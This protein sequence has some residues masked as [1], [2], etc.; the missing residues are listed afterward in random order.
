MLCVFNQ[1]LSTKPSTE[2]LQK[3]VSDGILN[4][5]KNDIRYILASYNHDKSINENKCNNKSGSTQDEQQQSSTRSSLS[6]EYK[7]IDS[8]NAYVYLWNVQDHVIVVD[9]DGTLTKSD[10]RGVISTIVKKDYT[11]VHDGMCKFFSDLV[12]LTRVP[13]HNIND[14]N[15]DD[16]NVWEKPVTETRF[17]ILPNNNFGIT[18]HSSNKN[19]NQTNE[20]TKLE[21]EQKYLIGKIRVLYLS[22]RPLQLMDSTRKFLS[23][24]S[25]CHLN[26][27]QSKSKSREIIGLTQCMSCFNPSINQ[28]ENDDLSKS[29]T[30][31]FDIICGDKMY[32]RHPDTLA[33]AETKPPSSKMLPDDW[34]ESKSAFSQLPAGPILLNTESLS[35]VLVSELNKSVYKYK[36]N[37]LMR[38]VVLPFTAAGKESNQKCTNTVS[39]TSTTRIKDNI[40]FIAGFGNKA[41][42]AKAYEIAGMRK[43]DIFIIDKKSQIS[44]YLDCWENNNADARKEGTTI[45]RSERVLTFSGYSDQDL[46][47]T[48]INKIKEHMT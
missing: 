19:Q 16:C 32:E 10:V 33:K 45:K 26:E 34:D 13:K 23:Q 29:D 6:C 22:S 31:D 48:M 5:G 42:D 1:G 43:E 4:E 11:H 20:I 15:T 47:K 30:C 21:K 3:L 46:T 35:S 27:R 44:C 38:Q 17:P 24:V 8:V 28:I 14:S 2:V 12:N 37:T 39:N 7:P 18:N 25:Q 40:I 9:I 36:A 41:T